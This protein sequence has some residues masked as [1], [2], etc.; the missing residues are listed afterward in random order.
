MSEMKKKYQAGDPITWL[1]VHNLLP[2]I[3]IIIAAIGVFNV[4]SNKVDLTEQR[5]GFVESKVDACLAIQSDLEGRLNAQGIGI[6]SSKVKG[7]STPSGE[8]RRATTPSGVERVEN[9]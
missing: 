1:Q 7:V 3:G 6:G 8:P 4:L 2:I 9:P 5:L